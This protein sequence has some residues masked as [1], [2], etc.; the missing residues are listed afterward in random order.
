M[1][2]T[3]FG[4]VILVRLVQPEKVPLPIN[5]GLSKKNFYHG[6]LPFGERLGVSRG[7]IKRPVK[8]RRRKI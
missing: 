4:M 5:K 3:L 1:L 6:V 2:V 7:A 8:G